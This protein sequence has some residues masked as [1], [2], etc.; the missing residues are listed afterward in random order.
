MGTQLGAVPKTWSVN[1]LRVQAF[2]VPVT[3]GP[4]QAGA[5]ENVFLEISQ[6]GPSFAYKKGADGSVTRYATN[7]PITKVKVHLMQ[8]SAGNAIFSAMLAADVAS[9]NG[10]GIGTFVAQDLNGTSVYAFDDAWVSGPPEA[11]FGKDP[12]ERVWELHMT[13]GGRVDGGN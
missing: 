10:A 4:G 6:D 2:G 7:E 12:T 13:N 8:T 3:K 1:Q 11:G 9:L 5:G